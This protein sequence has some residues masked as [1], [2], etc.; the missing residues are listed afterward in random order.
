MRPRRV[1]GFFVGTVVHRTG[2]F[3]GAFLAAS[4]LMFIASV[5]YSFVVG[6]IEPVAWKKSSQ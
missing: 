3:F 2:S 6:P 5:M 4:V 1:R